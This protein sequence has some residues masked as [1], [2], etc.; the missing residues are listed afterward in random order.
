MDLEHYRGCTGC[1]YRLIREK[2]QTKKN[3]KAEVTWWFLL[4]KP[5][6]RLIKLGHVAEG[7]S[8]GWINK[9]VFGESVNGI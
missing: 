8:G 1:G 5:R 2:K 4:Q 3:K 9:A 7:T 6:R